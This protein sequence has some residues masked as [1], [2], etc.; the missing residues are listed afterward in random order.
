ME[1]SGKQ[2]FVSK[3][4][5]IIPTYHFKCYPCT[6]IGLLNH[7]GILLKGMHNFYWT[8]IT[9]QDNQQVGNCIFYLTVQTFKCWSPSS[10]AYL[11]FIFVVYFSSVMFLTSVSSTAFVSYSLLLL[12]LVYLE[13]FL[14]IFLSSVI[15]FSISF[16]GLLDFFL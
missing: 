12:L 10:S 2:F 15:C 11:F 14:F 5:F 6:K 4:Y 3:K 8:L 7:L 1:S 9:Q 13:S 16:L